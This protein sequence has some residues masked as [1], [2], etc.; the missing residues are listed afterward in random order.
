MHATASDSSR[1]RL[2]PWL[3]AALALALVGLASLSRSWDAVEFKTFDLLT[4]LSAPQDARG[5]PIVVLA[6]DEPTF[7]ELQ[8]QWPF[9]RGLHA[10][11][12]QRL[13]AD[14]ATAVGFDVVFSEP[15]A[16]QDD[17]AFEA[18]L[19][20]GAP[21]VVLAGYEERIDNDQAVLWTQVAPLARF[22][23][24]GAETGDIGVRPD[25][26]YVVRRRPAGEDTFSARLA[27]H[28]GPS[29]G[30]GGGGFI[31]YL[32]PRGT[33]DTRSYYQAL[34]PGL[35]P[36]GFFRGKTVLVGRSART[37]AELQTARADTFNSPFAAAQAGDRLF[38]GVELQATLVANRLTGDGL[39]AVPGLWTAAGVLAL[40]AA[41]VW[42]GTGAHPWV[43]AGLAGALVAATLGLSW[44]LFTVARLWLP[45]LLPAAALLAVYAATALLGYLAVRRRA[46]QTRAMFA[47]YVPPEVVDRLVEHP[48]QMRLG[49]A[50]REVT[51][52]F[53]DL[54][55][56]TAMAE[57]LSAEQTVEVLTEYFGAMTPVIHR[58]RG[59]VDKF[60][61]DAIMAFWGAPL[62]DAG[63][64]AHALAAA[65]EM[66]QA[67][68]ALAARLRARRLPPI[69]M[70]IGLHS[71]RVVVGNVGSATR[72]SYT[73]IG[74]G[75]NLAARLEGANKAFGTGI[76][77]SGATAA[78]LDDDTRAGLRALDDVVV[79]GKSAP[80][81]VYTP[82]ADAGVRQRSAAA[83]DDF[84]ARRWDAAAA[85][86]RALLE[87]LPGDKAALHLLARIDAAR[88]LP[89]D[90]PWS[91]AVALDKL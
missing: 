87:R 9:P 21:S 49:G 26:D 23:R 33:I 17:D 56:F 68:E 15:G 78:L 66:Q 4:A 30:G 52:M 47:Q 20:G 14:G 81:R 31:A 57:R 72:F 29:G 50:E 42:W 37:A 75:V 5:L 48:E 84:T 61:G 73:A 10:R 45:P 19:R 38:P 3:A 7:Q 16:P 71:A 40:C 39:H 24:A 13:R 88:R 44:A 41:L 64:A 90:T 83:L 69:G 27:A 60:I 51:L 1:R 59:T 6:I 62:D 85:H 63:H 28:A 79:Q 67:M 35:L 34:E 82:C 22:T 76:L 86:L 36:A 2:A 25:D 74:D 80:V 53:T 46:A 55:S 54:A 89:P 8:T 32:G 91:P 58:H 11:L 43:G 12:L 77:L 65:V 18:A 70:R